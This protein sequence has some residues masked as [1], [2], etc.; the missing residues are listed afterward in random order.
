M[1]TA[2]S[3]PTQDTLAFLRLVT[4]GDADIAQGNVRPVEDFIQETRKMIKKQQKDYDGG[5]R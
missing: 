4:S 5:L 1:E 2:E 3:L